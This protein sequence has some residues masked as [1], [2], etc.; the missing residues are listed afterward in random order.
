M[1]EEHGIPRLPTSQARLCSN[2]FEKV[3]YPRARHYHPWTAVCV[4]L[5]AHRELLPQGMAADALLGR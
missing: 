2:R 5:F 1:K 4:L 3:L